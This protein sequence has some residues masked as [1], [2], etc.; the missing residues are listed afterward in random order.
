MLNVGSK[1][2]DEAEWPKFVTRSSVGLSFKCERKGLMVREPTEWPDL[3]GETEVFNEK[4]CWI[5]LFRNNAQ[6]LP[7]LVYL[8]MKSRAY[9]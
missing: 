4:V 6:Q 1:L 2:A 8:L 7:V 9:R 5:E 3:K